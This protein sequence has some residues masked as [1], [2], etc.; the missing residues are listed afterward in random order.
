MRFVA[1][2][3]IIG[4]SI[5]S[6]WTRVK[7]GSAGITAEAF[8][9]GGRPCSFLIDHEGKVH[10]VGQPIANGGRLVET[11]VSLLKKTGAHDVKAVSLETPRLKNAALTAA[12]ELFRARVEGG[13]RHRS[14]R[15][16]HGSC[17]RY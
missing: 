12:A 13:A 8:A 1:T 14:S 11:L 17:R 16:A 10:S 9:I 7:P 6:P 3:G 5:P 2:S 15:Q 4:S